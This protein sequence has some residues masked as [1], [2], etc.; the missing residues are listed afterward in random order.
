MNALRRWW[1]I[2]V[3]VLVTLAALPLAL[4]L[5]TGHGNQGWVDVQGPA[6]AALHAV[7]SRFGRQ[8]G[9]VIGVFADDVLAGDCMSWQ[10]RLVARLVA[11]P[12]VAG[13]DSLVTAVDVEVDEAGPGPVPLRRRA[14]QDILAHP[15]YR[16]LLVAGD[17]RAAAILAR[18]A[19]GVDDAGV[20]A[21]ETAVRQAIAELAPPPGV[22]ALVG[23]LPAQ[24]QAINRAVA[25]DQALTM[26]LTV[27]ALA[28]ILALTIMDG[29]VV[30]LILASLGSALVWTLASLAV[31]GCAMDAL[32]GLLPP[33]VM[34]MTVATAIHL[35]WSLGETGSMR[36]AAAPLLLATATTMAGVGGLYWGAVPAVQA[37]APWAALGTA[38]AALFPALWLAAG[39]RVLAPGR[40]TAHERGWCGTTLAGFLGR[41]AAWSA[42]R[43]V[44][45]FA[46]AGVLVAVSAGLCVRLR[47]DADFVHALPAH[48]A[49]R[50]AH[51]RIDSELTG[52]L[53]LDLL[54]DLGHAP[55]GGD[56]D[57]LDRL[58]ADLRQRPDITATLSLADVVALLRQRGDRRPTLDIVNDLRLGAPA[59]LGRVLSGTVLRLHA[60]QRDGSV[61][62]AAA[63]AE[64][65]R[66][67][68]QALFP[69]ASVSVA[70][71]AL[72]LDETTR[73]LLPAIANGLLVS[74]VLNAAL[75]LVFLRRWRL[76][77]A[78][79]VLAGVPLVVTYAA[80]PLLGWP[81]DVG[82]SMIACVALG[83][84]MDDAIHMTY[85][86]H[87]SA[88]VASATRRV[89]PPLVA[90]CVAL[91]GA[92]S[93][94]L[95]GEF[96]YTRSF[97]AM[98]ALAFVVGLMVNLVLA[99]ALVRRQE[100]TP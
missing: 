10:E 34:G 97:G 59:V 42:Q 89:G 75:L 82:V 14:R 80:L 2:V 48:D 5:G 53:G 44:L 73:R 81:L 25:A 87:R 22:S 13:V 30:L 8:D 15:L 71:G 31:A 57:A 67:Q 54:I 86:V 70:S 7:E 40:F 38:Y 68:A 83:I 76:A 94:C 84:I 98:L 93:L 27:L 96:T 91:A 52:V 21:C 49:V 11:L 65:L 20:V 51:A 12:G 29:A 33:L 3:L 4:R 88:D 18:L 46:V 23:G 95:L 92:F 43:R 39:S 64:T 58:A 63:T 85:A 19:V 1:P 9:L 69:R 41:L 74:L 35:T 62:A 45:V 6:Y 72:L 32:L 50:L 26:P 100:S 66:S 36:R 37:F 60:R 78:G 24:Q 16:G 99:P 56:I 17:G 28:A 55:S 47:P 90:A 61:A 79:L 77:L